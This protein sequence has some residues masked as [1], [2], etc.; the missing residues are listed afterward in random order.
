MLTTTAQSGHTYGLGMCQVSG[1]G[2]GHNGAHEGYL[3]VMAYD[4]ATGVST[5]AYCNFWDEDRLTTDQY[6][7]LVQ[8]AKDA[9]TAAG[10]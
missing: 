9:R 3:S 1:L 8:A 5:V 6:T 7:M 2:Y 4:P 10:Y